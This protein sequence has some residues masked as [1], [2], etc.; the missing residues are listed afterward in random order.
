MCGLSYQAG[1]Q[2][3]KAL[4]LFPFT[5]HWTA[6]NETHGCLLFALMPWPLSPV[7]PFKLC[8]FRLR[9][10]PLPS[11]LVFSSQVSGSFI[12]SPPVFRVRKDQ[13]LAGTPLAFLSP[14]DS[15]SS[16]TRVASGSDRCTLGNAGRR[17][18]NELQQAGPK[19]T[20]LHF[21]LDFPVGEEQ[22][23]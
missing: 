8:S 13:G 3:L 23:S 19:M 17:C 15:T 11:F 21:L 14:P 4:N 1:L 7:W 9:P 5:G 16:V 20:G 2:L 22:G 10:L 12:L 18:Q 6:C